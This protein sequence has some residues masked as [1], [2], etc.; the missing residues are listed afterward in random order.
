MTSLGCPIRCGFTQG[1]WVYPDTY[2]ITSHGN[3]SRAR[4]MSP[5]PHLIRAVQTAAARPGTIELSKSDATLVNVG[6]TTEEVDGPQVQRNWKH[7]Y[8]L[9]Q[10]KMAFGWCYVKRARQQ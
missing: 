8:V 9:M 3:R 7:H 1:T 10:E 5:M 4:A 2:P 6:E